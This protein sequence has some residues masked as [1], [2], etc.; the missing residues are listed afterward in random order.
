VLKKLQVGLK[1]WDR[2]EISEE[3]HTPNNRCGSLSVH[4]RSY[5]RA[6]HKNLEIR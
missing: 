3:S 2:I 4:S 6:L 5:Q 1:Y